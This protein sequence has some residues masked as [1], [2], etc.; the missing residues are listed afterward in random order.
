MLQLEVAESMLRTLLAASGAWSCNFGYNSPS[1]L[2]FGLTLSKKFFDNFISIFLFSIANGPPQ[3]YRIMKLKLK[4]FPLLFISTLHLVAQT[5]RTDLEKYFSALV[6]NQQFNGNVLVAENGKIVFEKSF[7]YADFSTKRLN[8]TNTLFPIASVTKTITATAI[9]QLVQSGKLKITAPAVEYLPDF[10][11]PTI[12]I[13]N[14]LSHTSGLP[15]YNA[16]FDSVRKQYP[17]KIFTNGDFLKGLVSNKKPLIYQP[18]EKGNYDNINYIVLA[19]ILEKVSGMSYGTYIEKNILKQAGMTN[20]F[21]FPPKLQY[22]QNKNDGFAFAYLSPH[23]YS[24][25][26]VKANTVPYIV[27]YWSAY[28]FTGFS[29][30]VSTTHDLLKYDEAYYN[31]NLLNK[32]IVNEAFTPMKLNNASNN[33][34]NFGLGWEIEHDSTLG[35]IVYHSGAATGLSCVLLRNISKHQTII[36][37][38]NT[39]YNAHEIAFNALSVLNGKL[40]P[41]PKK[42]I[43]KIYARVLLGDGPDAARDTLNV[44]KKDS[45]HYLLSEDEMNSLGY[46]FL[47]GTNNPN[48][49]HFPE[50]HKYL[51]A[52]KT[53]KLNIQLFPN[54]WNVYDSYGEALLI[55]G[56][57]EEAIKMY[58]KS[59]EL[60]PKNEGGKKALEKL[61]K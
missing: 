45:L 41:Y 44:L 32:Q 21:F 49:Y 18:G 28:N 30:Y 7:G 20:T 40:V 27:S 12:T 51:E 43:A 54:S 5:R 57:K 24:D 1:A 17:D 39:H 4:I 58:N 31:G 60:N 59:I 50:E 38:D 19:L 37:F 26:L 46:D 53:F 11:Y 23:I 2:A 13:K 16:Y 55:I 3:D 29:D 14:L 35:K 9:L 47:G 52:V 36:L 15:P 33:P 10:P 61:L 42:S 56:Q 34:D 48:P 22:A 6:Q 25:S 8:S